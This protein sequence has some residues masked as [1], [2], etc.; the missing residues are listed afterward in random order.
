MWD[1][2]LLVYNDWPLGGNVWKISFYI[3]IY[4]NK[5]LRLYSDDSKICV[6]TPNRLFVGRMRMLYEPPYIIDRKE[7]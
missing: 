7:T 1:A 4:G 6:F 3:R 2:D 5:S